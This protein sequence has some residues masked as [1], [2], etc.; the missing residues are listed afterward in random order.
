MM[1]NHQE[2]D[3]IVLRMRENDKKPP[4]LHPYPKG[5]QL[6]HLE[7]MQSFPLAT[8]NLSSQLTIFGLSCWQGQNFGDIDHP[9]YSKLGVLIRI[10]IN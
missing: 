3:E 5:K 4:P 1:G 9:S 2:L 7:C 8:W 6:G 10:H